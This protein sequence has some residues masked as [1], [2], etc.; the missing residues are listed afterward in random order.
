MIFT[1][2]PSARICVTSAFLITGLRIARSKPA[3]IWSMP[4]VGWNIVACMLML[5]SNS[6]APICGWPIR[7]RN[8]AGSRALAN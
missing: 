6:V 8:A 5:S 4:P 7:S 2:L 1:P 3:M